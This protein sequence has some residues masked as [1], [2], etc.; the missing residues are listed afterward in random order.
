MP[1]SQDS[2]HPLLE[3]ARAR[4]GTLLSDR[5]RLVDLLDLGGMAAVYDARDRFDTPVAIKV[6]HRHHLRTPPVVRGFLRESFVSQVLQHRG[7]ARFLAE[8]VDEQGVPFSVMERLQGETLH[9]RR[10]REGAL[11]WRAALKILE[12]VLSPL[13]AAHENGIV[14]ADIKPKNIFLLSD[15]STKLLDFGVA[16]FLDLDLNLRG[17]PGGLKHFLPPSYGT[18]GYMP[19][20]Q[21]HGLLENIDE[22]SDVWACGALFTAMVEGAPSRSS[23]RG[24]LAR[25]PTGELTTGA[26]HENVVTAALLE[27]LSTR[28][29]ADVMRSATSSTRFLPGVPAAVSEVIEQALRLD[30]VERWPNAGMMLRALRRAAPST[31]L[32]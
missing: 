27:D 18:P 23:H 21:V 2:P 15:G 31:L 6:L 20:E 26:S 24:T 32:S 19:P 7:V 14:H 22:R 29:L 28:T 11:S 5:W 17:E 12:G 10:L 13:A 1:T 9:A 3:Q 4:I 30:P 25:A 8:D 16:R